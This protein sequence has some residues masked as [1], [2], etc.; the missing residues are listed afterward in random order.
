MID[1]QIPDLPQTH[2]FTVDEVYKMYEHGILPPDERLELI[3]GQLYRMSP[4]NPPHVIVLRKLMSFFNSHL[5]EE[6]YLVDKEVPLDISKKTVPEPDLIVARQRP[7]LWEDEHIKVSDVEL[8]I[9]V[10]DSSLQ[11]DL[12][13]KKDLYESVGV[14]IYWVINLP[15]QQ[16]HM[17]SHWR[18]GRYTVSTIYKEGEILIEPLNLSISFADIFPKL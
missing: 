16:I 9:E 6:S 15:K 2:S 12:S 13:T 17:F 14:P 10:A 5:S 7:A 18:N 4:K 3:D 1:Y 8:L 11:F